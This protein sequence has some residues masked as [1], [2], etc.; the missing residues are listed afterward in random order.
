MWQK[1]V[2]VLG[3]SSWNEFGKQIFSN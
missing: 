1:E 2:N 3:S